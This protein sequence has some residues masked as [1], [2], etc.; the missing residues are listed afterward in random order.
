MPVFVIENTF[1][2]FCDSFQHAIDISMG[3][4]CAPHLVDLFVYSNEID[5][6]QCCLQTKNPAQ[7]YDMFF[8]YFKFVRIIVSGT[9]RTPVM[10]I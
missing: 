10:K 2:I 3:T 4:N 1:V 5:F 9:E 6:I 8:C 7:S